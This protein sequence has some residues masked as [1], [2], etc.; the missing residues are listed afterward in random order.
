MMSN[1]EIKI[2]MNENLLYIFDNCLLKEYYIQIIFNYFCKSQK[3]KIYIPFIYLCES[4]LTNTTKKHYEIYNEIKNMSK[5]NIIVIIEN[6]FDTNNNLKKKYLEYLITIGGFEN[7][8]KIYLINYNSIINIDNNENFINEINL[9]LFYIKFVNIN[10]IHFY[11][12]LFEN[13]NLNNLIEELNYLNTNSKKIFTT[14]NK[15]LLSI[16]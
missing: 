13:E 7:D 12:F 10:F 9:L 15:K 8:K 14:N 11:N 1:H 6:F 3:I 5:N 16:Y 2:K 4:T